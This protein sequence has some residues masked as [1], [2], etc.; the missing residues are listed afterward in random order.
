MV[1]VS[2]AAGCHGGWRL[3]AGGWRLE[4][5]GWRLEAGGWRLERRCVDR[6]SSGFQLLASSGFV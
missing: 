1:T 2:Q 5:G 6:L 4:A 3:E